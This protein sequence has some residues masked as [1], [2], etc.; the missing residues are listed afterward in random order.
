MPT[1]FQTEAWT[2]YAV[3]TVILL[4][5]IV[6]R[7]SQVR[8]RW[9]GDDYFAVL[10]VVFFTA[11]L[12]MLELIGQFGSITGMNDATALTL[13]PEQLRRIVVGSKCPLAGW[14]VYTTLIWCLKACLL[15]FYNQLTYRPQKA[16]L[17][18]RLGIMREHVRKIQPSLLD[19]K[20]ACSISFQVAQRVIMM[21]AHNGLVVPRDFW[22]VQC[23]FT[24]L[25]TLL[26]R[27]V[28]EIRAW[29]GYY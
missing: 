20:P 5:R 29:L 22:R 11:E 27:E 21:I 10:A 12:V 3:D 17:R 28:V 24:L 8:W 1:P 7:G 19:Q 18:G 15:F 16:F 26:L 23:Y 4:T 13:T 2:E 25:T 6:A 14:I 9:E